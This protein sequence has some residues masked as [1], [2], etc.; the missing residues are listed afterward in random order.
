MAGTDGVRFEHAGS[1]AQRA[2]QVLADG[3]VATPDMAQRVLGITGGG[4]AAARAVWALLGSDPRFAV[5]GQGVW[6]LAT[7]APRRP[8]SLR[9]EE[10][11]VVDFETTG[12]SPTGGHRVTEVAA[13]RVSGGE[14]RGHYTSL[15][16]PERRIPGMITSITG[17]TQ[18]MV[19]GAPCFREVAHHVGEAVEGA[20]F[21]AHNAAFDWRFLCHEMELATGVK[22]AG[23]QLCTVKMARKLL[24]E[25]PSRGLD[26]LSV[27]FGLEIENRHRALDDAVATAHVLLRLIGMLEDRGVHDWD[28]LQVLLGARKPPKSRKRSATPRS[29][30]AA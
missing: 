14:I 16:N 5:D 4:A 10:W 7:D 22:P 2:L 3:P 26:A 24:P 15:I 13:V 28:D 11:V 12:G 21:V 29:M 25:L 18:Q 8:R 20:V 17:I 1:L 23:R 30:E 9:D 6:S 27:Y 19:D